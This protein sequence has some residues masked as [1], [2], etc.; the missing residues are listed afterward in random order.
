MKPFFI[1]LIAA[2]LFGCSKRSGTVSPPAPTQIQFTVT[3]ENNANASGAAVKLYRTLSDYTNGSNA[4][5]PFFTGSNGQVTIGSTVALESIPYYVD[6]RLGCKNNALLDNR[7]TQ[8]PPAGLTS[9]V[10]AKVQSTG[11]IRLVNNSANPYRIYINGLIWISSMA[12]GTVNLP[13]MQARAY[14]IR[15]LQISGYAITPTD[16]TYTGTLTCG[17]TLITNFP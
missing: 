3:D 7:L 14:S 6:I 11:T 8:A 9:T 10:T 15:V 13:D 5:G 12:S 1:F 2:A 4:I 17:S 16:Q